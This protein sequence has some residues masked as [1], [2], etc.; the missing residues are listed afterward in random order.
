MVSQHMF[1]QFPLIPK[2]LQ[3]KF[4][5]EIILSRMQGQMFLPRLVTAEAFIA[6]F[7]PILVDALVCA[8][9]PFVAVNGTDDL[10]AVGAGHPPLRS[11]EGW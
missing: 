3:A 6:V 10:V 11:R 7:T 8:N 9:V 2:I 4:A 5:L 1:F